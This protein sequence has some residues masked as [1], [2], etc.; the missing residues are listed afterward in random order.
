MVVARNVAFIGDLKGFY[1]AADVLGAHGLR[2]IAHHHISDLRFGLIQR[3]FH[4]A[5]Q[6][7]HMNNEY[8]VAER[9]TQLQRLVIR[10]VK[11]ELKRSSKLYSLWQSEREAAYEVAFAVADSRSIGRM[12][13]HIFYRRL[14]PGITIL[15][16]HRATDG[17]RLVSLA[18]PNHQ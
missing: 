7:N 4:F 11:G 12:H 17:N 1:R 10:M 14:L 6:R 5:M 8:F 18:L 3:S 2:G 15:F 16:Q 9:L 13:L